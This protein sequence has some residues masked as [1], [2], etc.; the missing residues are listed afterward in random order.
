MGVC[1]PSDLWV[2][3]DIK[4]TVPA[5]R[6][7][8]SNHG[9]SGSTQAGMHTPIAEVSGHVL[10]TLSGTERLPHR[11][12]SAVG[13]QELF[14]FEGYDSN[15]VST[16]NTRY[17]FF[18]RGASFPVFCYLCI[19][20]FFRSLPTFLSLTVTWPA[21]PAFCCTLPCTRAQAASL[22]SSGACCLSVI[23]FFA[24][25]PLVILCQVLPP[26]AL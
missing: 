4:S 7:P 23:F 25:G 6:L 8:L 18:L 3:A 24:S 21:N 17:F 15:H 11:S 16:K 5:D 1:L 19:Y 12:K 14:G 20:F 26:P 2:L 10:G 13:G 22:A 9:G